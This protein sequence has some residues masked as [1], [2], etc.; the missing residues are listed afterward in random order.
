MIVFIE[1]ID[2]NLISIT[3]KVGTVM[4][5]GTACLALF[6]SGDISTGTVYGIVTR[7]N[8]QGGMFSGSK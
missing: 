8:I 3:L 1:T 6:L 4:A 2:E 5:G 7:I